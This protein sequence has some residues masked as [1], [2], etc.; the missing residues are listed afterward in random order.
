MNVQD[1]G[2]LDSIFDPIRLAYAA[3]LRY[4]QARPPNQPEINPLLFEVGKWQPYKPV[5]VRT[6]PN[7]SSTLTTESTTTEYLQFTKEEIAKM[8][9]TFKR[10]FV[11][12]GFPARCIKRKSGKG[13][14]YEFRYRRNGFNITAASTDKEAAKE[15]FKKKLYEATKP[16]KASLIFKDI[17]EEWFFTRK[18]RIAESTYKGYYSY[19]QRVILPQIGNRNITEIRTAD[20]EKIMLLVDGQG[21][22]YEDVRS[23]LNQIFTYAEY[24]GLI[25][26]NP[27]KLVPFIRSE[28]EHGT[29]LR[30]DEE[31]ALL[32]ALERPENARIRQPILTM[33]YFGLRPC[34]LETARFEGGFII[35]QNAK[36]KGKKI[37]YKKIPISPMARKYMDFDISPIPCFCVNYIN[38]LFKKILPNHHQYDLRHTFSTRCQ[39]FVRREIV[40]VWLGDSSDRLI[41]NTYTHFPDDFMITEINK[42][43]Y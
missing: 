39:Q 14:C 15:K 41:G 5:Q 6:E 18:A 2:D 17:A 8:Q 10:E 24:N 9:K 4:L 11:I 23:I 31:E 25:P 30:K 35:C 32:K 29:M 43:N 33:L 20:L 22:A 27:V 3:I 1:Y 36:R 13:I 38:K 42:V 12:D 16:K 37:E 21:R 34:E 7:K 19:Y 28:R 26:R 40:E